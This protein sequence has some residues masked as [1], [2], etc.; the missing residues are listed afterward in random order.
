MRASIHNT[1]RA[2]GGALIR[3]A[4]E[5]AAH[6]SAQQAGRPD[7]GDGTP[8]LHILSCISPFYRT[9]HNPR[10]ARGAP[11]SSFPDSPCNSRSRPRAGRGIR[12]HHLRW[13]R[14]TRHAR[15][16]RTHPSSLLSTGF[17]CEV[18]EG[19]GR[20]PRTSVPRHSMTMMHLICSYRKAAAAAAAGELQSHGSKVVQRER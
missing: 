9:Q 13:Q 19:L 1:P 6:T 20:V 3:P 8:S 17:F 2:H 18:R 16:S 12:K 7:T 11:D 4:N 10:C 5:L 15:R 14:T